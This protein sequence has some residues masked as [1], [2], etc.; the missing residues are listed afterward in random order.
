MRSGAR[1]PATLACLG[2]SR[3]TTSHPIYAAS[4]EGVIRARLTF[5]RADEFAAGVV[6]ISVSFY[7]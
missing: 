3:T 4:R 7:C 2:G 6:D 5:A 1:A